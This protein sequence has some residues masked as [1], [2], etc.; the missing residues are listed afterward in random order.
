MKLIVH[1]IRLRTGADPKTFEDWVLNAD[2]AAC[3]RL[4]SVAAFSVQRADPG[5]GF[6]YFEVISVRSQAD[7]EADM[8]GADFAGLVASFSEMA[9]VIEEIGGARLGDG[10]RQGR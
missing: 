6:D 7:F 9:E 10:Y 8:R 4:P 1:K 2:Y 3:P 5:S